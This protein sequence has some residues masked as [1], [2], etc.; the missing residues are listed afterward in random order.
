MKIISWNINGIRSVNQKDKQGKKITNNENENVINSIITEQSP[1]IICLQEIKCSDQ[2]IK[3]FD[4]YKTQYPYIY[5]C[6]STKKGY[7]GV[8]ILSKIEPKKIMYNFEPLEDNKLDHNFQT[9]GRIITLEFDKF[10]LL[11]VYTLNSKQ[12]LE[13]LEQRT[14]VWEPLFRKMIN[15]LQKDKPVILMGDLNVAYND[16]DI[17]STKGKSKSAGFTDEERK[18]FGKL[19]EE[20]EMID[21]FRSIYPDKIQYTYFSNFA[22]SRG[23]NKGW[24]IDYS[25]VSKKLKSKVIDSTIHNQYFGSDHCPIKL[26]LSV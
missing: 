18:E 9:E 22:N 21:T 12:K 4:R 13:R 16:I 26:E 24:R 11:S 14:T 20:C 1:N 25:C 5:I 15:K 2:H 8:A 3:D 19:I 23:N 10:Y 6:C 17:H 7:A